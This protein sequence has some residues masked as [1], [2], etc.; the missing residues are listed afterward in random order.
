[1]NSRM[2]LC[3]QW[4]NIPRTVPGW[5][6]LEVSRGVSGESPDSHT[7]LQK[8]LRAVVTIRASATLVIVVNTHTH[9]HTHTMSDTHTAF[10]LP[11]Y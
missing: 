11:Y 4:R 5:A 2:S 8:P 6:Y 10:E 1:M 9:I 7:R 3:V